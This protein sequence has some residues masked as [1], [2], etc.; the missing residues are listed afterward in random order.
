M[1]Q[2]VTAEQV[3]AVLTALAE[4]YLVDVPATHDGK[5]GYFIEYT[6]LAHQLVNSGIEW[7]TEISNYVNTK[8]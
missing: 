5:G 6:T 1:S 4:E 7:Y 3:E 8:E 2:N